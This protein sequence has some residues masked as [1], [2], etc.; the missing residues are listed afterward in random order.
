VDVLDSGTYEMYPNR[1]S[2]LYKDIYGLEGIP[3]LI[4][5]TLRHR[6]FCDAWS[7]LVKLGLTDDTYPIVHAYDMT[8][9]Q[10]IHAFFECTDEGLEAVV[11]AYL[12]VPLEGEVMYQLRWLGLFEHVPINMK[13]V[14][15][16][17]IMEKLL[18]SKWS[19][20]PDDK[21]LV[22]MQHEFEYELDGELKKRTSALSF[23]GDDA[24]NTAMS[25]LV[26]LPLGIFMKHVILGNI[27]VTGVNIP[28]QK[29]V[30][31]PVLAELEEYGVKFV[32]KEEVLDTLA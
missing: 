4:R 11:A 14:T 20:E 16:A 5:G 22:V 13:M 29:E 8:Y 15:P 3:T 17:G 27:K 1:D 7:A 19:M 23:E 28:T 18:L 9:R 21:D 30:Y 6:G 12:H 24:L 32:E 10:L 26:G 2:L 25:K 31:V